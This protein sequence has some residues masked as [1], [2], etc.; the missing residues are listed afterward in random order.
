MKT[1]NTILSRISIQVWLMLLFVIY[2]ILGWSGYGTD[3]DSY[4]MIRSG[5]DFWLNGFYHYSRGPGNLIPELVIG[6]ASIL[7]GHYLT[8]LI[9][10]LLGIGTLYLMHQL[11]RKAFTE[12]QSVFITLMV[13]L[14]PWYV[15]ASSSSMDYVYSLFMGFAG[16]TFLSKNKLIP[17]TLLFALAISSRLTT[18]I[19]I[20]II[21]LYYLYIRFDEKNFTEI[22]NLF[23]SGVTLLILV[24][25]LFIPSWYAADCTFK[26]LEYGIGDWTIVEFLARIIYKNIYL[27]SPLILLVVGALIVKGLYKKSF[28][29]EIT[30]AVVAGASMIMIM[31]LLFIKIPCEIPYLVPPFIIA[32]PLLTWLGNPGKTVMYILLILSFSFSFIFNPDFLDR[33]Y[34]EDRTEAIS[35]EVGLFIRKGVVIDDILGREDAKIRHWEDTLKP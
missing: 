3:Y 17:A 21:Y 35:A 20:G 13:A 19:L 34:N 15:I 31:E 11:L 27:V 2:L 7:G 5:R 23:I 25:I 29:F 1:N 18:I 32:I 12:E 6:G 10:A 24:V 33:K 14:N 26:F 16:L 30:P 9:S 22:R 28:R 8:N 4:A